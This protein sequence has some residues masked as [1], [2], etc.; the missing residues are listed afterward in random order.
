M[1]RAWKMHFSAPSQWNEMC[2]VYQR[3]IFQGGEKVKIYT[4]AYGQDGSGDPPPWLW[5]TRV[6]FDGFPLY[7]SMSESCSSAHDHSLAP[8]WG[9]THQSQRPLRFREGFIL[10]SLPPCLRCR[11]NG[12]H[13]SVTKMRKIYFQE[14][15]SKIPP[16]PAASHP[17]LPL[18]VLQSSSPPS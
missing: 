4:F 7:S 1:K 13:H 17:S 15:V 18:A 10:I 2:F 12:S 11:W 9:L 5:N 6:Y 14:A 8:R 16:I 3:I